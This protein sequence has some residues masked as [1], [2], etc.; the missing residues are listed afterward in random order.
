MGNFGDGKIN[1]FN[2]RTGTFLG[3]LQDHQGQ[4]IAIEGLWGLAFNPNSDSDH[5]A[6]YFSAGPNDETDG[7]LGLLRPEGH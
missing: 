3:Q 1:A 6:L 4:P 7:L 5:P 2:A